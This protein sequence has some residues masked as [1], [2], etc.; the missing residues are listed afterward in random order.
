VVGP[1]RLKAHARL[2]AVKK[3]KEQTLTALLAAR[4]EVCF[5]DYD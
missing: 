1:A 4:S 5:A 2:A 3:E